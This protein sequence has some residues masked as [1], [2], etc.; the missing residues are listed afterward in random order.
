MPKDVKGLANAIIN[1]LQDE[2]IANVM[3]KKGRILIEKKYRWEE[4][5][6]LM[7][8]VYEAVLNS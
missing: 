8:R 5:G 2:E 6:E 1:V 4:V 7:L 3:G